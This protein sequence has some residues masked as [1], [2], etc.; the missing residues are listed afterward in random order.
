MTIGCNYVICNSEVPSKNN[1]FV[2][3]LR[4]NFSGDEFQI[5]DGGDNPDRV[6]SRPRKHLGAVKKEE[7]SL[8]SGNKKEVKIYMVAPKPQESKVEIEGVGQYQPLD[9][10][11]TEKNSNPLAK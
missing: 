7:S 10:T 2:G 9:F 6:K 1:G 5:Y 8:W 3:K 11:C 4:G